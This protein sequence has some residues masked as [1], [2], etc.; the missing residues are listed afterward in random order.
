MLNTDNIIQS[1]TGSFEGT[2]GSATLPVGTEVGS[3]VLIVVGMAGN[4]STTYSA[5]VSGLDEAAASVIG[6][7][8]AYPYVFIE[9]SSAGAET[10]W[11]I[12]VTGGSQQV[13][14]AVLEMSNVDVSEEFIVGVP[15]KGPYL[16]AGVTPFEQTVIASLSSSS[17]SPSDSYDALALNLF[18]ATSVDTTVPVISGYTNGFF[19]I[20]TVNRANATR[21]LTMSIVA[22]PSQSLGAFEVTASVSPSS[23]LVSTTLVLT[24]ASGRHAPNIEA[25]SGFE[26][27]TATGLTTASG[28]TADGPP[29]FD[30]SVGSPAIV[31]TN[32]RTGS[33]CLE[34]SAAAAAE[35]VTWTAPSSGAQGN[36]NK[37]WGSGPAIETKRLHFLFPTSLPGADVEIASAE[38]TSLANGV[39]VWY[40]S[41]SQKI[42]V[43]VGTGSEVLSDAV[44]AADLWIG[45]DFCYDPRTTTH[46]FDWQVDYDS[47]D[48]TGPVTQSQA[49]G[50]GMTAGRVTTDRLGWT[51]S[52]TATVRYDDVVVCRIRKAYPIGDVN[53]RPLRVDPA[54][55]LT[56]SGTS[57]NFQT[58][59][60]NGTGAA[61]NSAVGRSNISDIPPVVG[62]SS[63][64]IMQVATAG[65][66]Y[67]EIPMDTWTAAPDHV[68]RA[69]RWYWAPWAA[70]GTAA[71]LRFDILDDTLV[72]TVDSLADHNQDNAALFWLGRMHRTGSASAFYVLSQAKVDAF[73]C[74]FGFSNDA[75]PDVGM[76][77]VLV[78]LVT[79]PAI[80]Y[81]VLSVEGNAFTVYVRQDPFSAAVASYLVTTPE[82]SRGATFYA[83]VDGTPT[84]QYV[85]PNTTYE[86]VIGAVDV[87]QVTSIG[88]APDPTV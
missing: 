82:G 8:R 36:L 26:V 59:T 27:G 67:I 79:Q 33:Y 12:T 11:T 31:T 17:T 22:K 61:W 28:I 10:S 55:T 15:V 69:A 68:L 83:T 25:C 78:E 71:T 70:T 16:Q 75:A 52:R 76:H 44:V 86:Q 2:S 50:S 74:R 62:A 23:Y 88:L 37:G 77:A 21:A 85:A 35:C 38:V 58:F 87:S 14:W 9:Q 63:N 72:L 42:G 54:G 1:N 29:P 32:P 84:E 40:R 80:V 3:T 6:A 65:S 20:A 56:I 13:C 48:V 41:A 39:T 66:D 45:L 24:S 47:Q 73:R 60:A 34:L 19:E 43:V 46:T 57:T 53:V 18:L 5:T 7:L 64:G 30:G 49:T 4:G 51:V 81:G